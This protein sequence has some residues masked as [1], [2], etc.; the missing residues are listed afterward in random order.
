M[1]SESGYE[2]FR[3]CTGELVIFKFR[4]ASILTITLLVY[5][6]AADAVPTSFANLSIGTFS[7]LVATTVNVSFTVILF[8]ILASII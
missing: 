3:Y 5:A 8:A 6:K 7:A 1:V 2:M 4:K